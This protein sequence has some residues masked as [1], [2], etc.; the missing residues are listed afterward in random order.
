MFYEIVWMIYTLAICIFLGAGLLSLTYSLSITSRAARAAT[1]AFSGLI[2]II[3]IY[4]SYRWN[5]D[6]R[7]IQALGLKIEQALDLYMTTHK[8]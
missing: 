1:M 8:K 5:A 2:L 3:G 4:F 7:E 6:K